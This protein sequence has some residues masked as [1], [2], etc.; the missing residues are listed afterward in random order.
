MK[1]CTDCIH[2]GVCYLQGAVDINYA[3]K[4]GDYGVIR[5]GHW[6]LT[7]DEQSYVCSCCNDYWIGKSEYLSS[8]N[9]CPN[10]GARMVEPQESEG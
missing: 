6:K 1:L 4:C 10:C 9:F 7:N 3:D 8:W 5:K 2:V